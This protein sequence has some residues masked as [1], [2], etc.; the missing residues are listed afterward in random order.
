MEWW[1]IILIV[2]VAILVGALLGT[3]AGWLTLRFALQVRLPFRSISYLAFSKKREAPPV[4]K[5]QVVKEETKLTVPDLVAEVSYNRKIATEPLGDKL[6][7]FQTDA[8]DA[9]QYEAN[10][11]PA[12]L[13]G[14][15]QQVYT[16]IRLANSIA[17]ISTEFNR[18]T[19]SMDEHY[20]RL[21]TIIAERLDKYT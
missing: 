12:N 19:S 14:D 2:L 5:E 18:R 7:L 21:C 9:H 3:L 10:Q 1:Q 13:R 6:L 16:D 11:L 4:V 17:W 15:L 20:Q 8:W